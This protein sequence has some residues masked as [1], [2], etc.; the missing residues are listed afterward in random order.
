[1]QKWRLIHSGYTS[2]ARNMAIDEAITVAVGEGSVP[3]TIRFYGWNPPCLSLG[4]A[5]K[6]GEVEWEVCRQ[7]GV[8]VVRRPTGGRAILHDQEVT[9]SLTAPEEDPL[10]S[11]SI[12]ES[13]LKIS[14]GL[15]AGMEKIGIKAEIVSHKDLSGLG[16]GACFDSPSFYELVVQGR[17]AVGSAQT[18]KNGTVLQHGS[19]IRELDVEQ[20]FAVL[21]F[22]KSEIRARMKEAFKNKACSL[23]EVAGRSL[24][25]QEIIQAMGQG[26]AEGLG[27]DLVTGSLSKR[28][29]ELAE[30]LEL[31]K[32]NSVEWN[33]KR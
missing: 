5:Q 4:Y 25:D 10:V 15:L 6:A 16:T 13:Y 17:K 1:M 29:L 7:Y 12:L 20:L 11:G 22:P 14:R 31:N 19:I 32:Y 27:I 24:T 8:D 2:G 28:E 23:Q 18:R 9:Y 3:P 33:Q 30:E 26:F 21:H